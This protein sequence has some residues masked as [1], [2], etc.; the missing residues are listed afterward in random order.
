MR[1]QVA[2]LQRQAVA[3]MAPEFARLLNVIQWLLERM[4]THRPGALR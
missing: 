2:G 1:Q 3:E 4:D